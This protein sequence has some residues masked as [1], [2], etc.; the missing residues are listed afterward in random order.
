MHI[1]MPPY[2][3]QSVTMDFSV[4]VVCP[5]FSGKPAFKSP[6]ATVLN[7]LD[8]EQPLLAGQGISL[9]H[10]SHLLHATPEV[11]NQTCHLIVTQVSFN[12][13]Q[14][15][16][17]DFQHE[18]ITLEV[19]THPSQPQPPL[20]P[21]TLRVS[22]TVQ[23]TWGLWGPVDTVTVCSNNISVPGEVQL[24]TMDWQ[25]N[26]APHLRN[27]FLLI[28]NI[29]S[30]M[31]WYCLQKTSCHTFARAIFEAINS[32][33]NHHPYLVQKTF[34][35]QVSLFLGCIPVGINKVTKLSQEVAALYPDQVG[36]A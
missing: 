34:F 25:L 9:Q 29:Q 19:H 15:A 33:L 14:S 4:F 36:L 16:W 1:L 21:V 6:T 26:N 17:P 13:V 28:R 8:L 12:K 30:R 18:S 10:W 32:A 24:H 27:V 22:H 35:S 23:L 5:P 31:P 7:S 20:A 3:N 2:G 11:R